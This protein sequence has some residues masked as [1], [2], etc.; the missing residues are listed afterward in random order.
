MKKISF[1]NFKGGVGKTT[2]AVNMAKALAK[3]GKKVLVVD[4]DPQGNASKMMGFRPMTD[5][6]NALY[7]ALS[8]MDIRACI[9]T[10]ESE[11]GTEEVFDFIPST[12]D[13][14]KCEQELVSRTGREFILRLALQ[15]IENLYDFV[16]IDCPPNYGLLT[17]N[18][19]CASDFL[20]IPINCEVFALDGMGLISA[21]HVEIKQMINPNLEVLGYLMSRYDKRLTLHREAVS[22]MEHMFPGK[23]FETRIRTNIQL[24]ESPSMR[25]NIF[26]FAPDSVGASDYEK[27]TREFLYK[28]EQHELTG[29]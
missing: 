3:V 1:L 24:A 11:N 6:V 7:D 13:L 17:V 20:I 8:G 2:S 10:S 23:V 25:T 15:P 26:D 29:G 22:Q 21:K 12:H 28:V 14:Y 18:A 4:V 16:F 5:K 19:M 9:Y 27:L